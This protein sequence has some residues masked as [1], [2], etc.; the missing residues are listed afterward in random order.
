MSRIT[1]PAPAAVAAVVALTLVECSPKPEQNASD[2]TASAP[3]STPSASGTPT[4]TPSAASTPSDTATSGAVE[5]TYDIA[6]VVSTAESAVSGSRAW[7]LDWEDDRSEWEVTVVAGD[8]STEVTVSADGA[9]VLSQRA[10]DL[11]DAE[12]RAEMDATRITLV[13]AASTARDEVPGTID[14]VSLD[15]ER[16][17]PRWEVDIRESGQL[18][19]TDVIINAT[20]GDVLTVQ[21]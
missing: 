8:Q 6:A 17:E 5:A 9:S 1:R 14:S 16:G 18:R 7:D 10:D 11:I 19:T 3:Q 21:R 20:T 13:E 2:A 12:D 15:D 4:S